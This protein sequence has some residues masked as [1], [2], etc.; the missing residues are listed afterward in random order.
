MVKM[1]DLGSIPAKACSAFDGKILK[2]NYLLY[3]A[4]GAAIIGAY[5]IFIK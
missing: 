3:A 4:I 1:P 2:T 5:F